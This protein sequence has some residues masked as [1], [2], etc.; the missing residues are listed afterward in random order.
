MKEI[1]AHFR[2]TFLFFDV[3]FACWIYYTEEA[4]VSFCASEN[5]CGIDFFLQVPLYVAEAHRECGCLKSLD[6]N[7]DL[8]YWAGPHTTFPADDWGVHIFAIIMG[9]ERITWL[10]SDVFDIGGDIFCFL[11]LRVHINSIYR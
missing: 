9:Q 5:S 10:A 7:L 3:K 2:K 6:R 4:E 1:G 8:L 11:V